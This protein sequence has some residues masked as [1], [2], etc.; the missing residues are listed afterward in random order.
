VT[1]RPIRFARVRRLS[2]RFVRGELN[3][4]LYSQIQPIDWEF[5]WS[6]H[7]EG[8][9]GLTGPVGEQNQKCARS[10]KQSRIPSLSILRAQWKVQLG[11]I[12]YPF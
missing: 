2:A 11:V 7:Q 9:F 12:N 8:C 5:G 6:Q 4:V 10:A 1:S 3:R